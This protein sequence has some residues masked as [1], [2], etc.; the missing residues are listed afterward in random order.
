M[1]NLRTRKPIRLQNY[2]YSENGY[3]FVSICSGNR[4][5]ILTENK[6]PVGAD[7]RPAP[8]LSDIICSFKSRSSLEY[9]RYIKRNNLNF[10]DKFW[11]RSY[12]DN[13]IRNERSL[14]AI[15]EYILDTPANWEQDIENL[16]DL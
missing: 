4:Q 15:R 3:Y 14:S 9:I 10:S 11:Q 13:V 1:N 16:L 6:S 8:T 2:D 7:T 5:N 12:Y